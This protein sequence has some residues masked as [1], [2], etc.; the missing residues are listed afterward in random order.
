[1]NK[2]LYNKRIELPKDVV[3]YLKQCY[4]SLPNVDDSTDGYRRNKEL[5]NSGY[6][7]YQQLKR[8]KN[9]FDNFNGKQDEPSF[10]LNGADYVK[11]WVNNTLNA[12]RDNDDRSKEIK[13]IVQ[14]NQYIKPHTKDNIKN[15]NRPSKSHNTAL[16]FFDLEVTEN[17]KRINELIKKII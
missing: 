3:V 13:S 12:W 6:A 2:N 11:G 4:D 10:I 1:M 15:L 7:T 9:F 16:G 8:V 14:P 17:L 5:R